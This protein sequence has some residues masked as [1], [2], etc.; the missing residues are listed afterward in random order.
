MTDPIADMLTRIRNASTVKKTEV[1]LPYSNI[2]FAVAK[3]LSQAGYLMTAEKLDQDNG[4]IRLVLKYQN[5]QPMIRSIRRVSTP[6]HRVY[7]GY[8]DLPTVLSDQGV[9]VVSTSQGVMTNKDAR[10]RKLGGEILCEV[11]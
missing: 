6:S 3:V 2:K 9:V 11:F 5:G 8:A 1:V 7:L 4:Q 10:K